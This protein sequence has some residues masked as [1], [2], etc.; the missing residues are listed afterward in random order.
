[1]PK[2]SGEHGLGAIAN[3]TRFAEFRRRVEPA[4]LVA[5]RALYLS[6]SAWTSR[7]LRHVEELLSGESGRVAEF[8]ALAVEIE[9]GL[10]TLAT[11]EEITEEVI[12]LEGVISKKGSVD[13][14]IYVPSLIES[15]LGEGISRLVLQ[16]AFA[17]RREGADWLPT[18]RDCLETVR[19]EKALW[20]QKLKL[21]KSFP[22]ALGLCQLRLE[23]EQLFPAKQKTRGVH[24]K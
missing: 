15:L 2:V 18:I 14:R 17:K 1:M 7:E 24:G 4:S 3:I 19:D 23:R 6:K 9:M 20:W 11:K 10:L 5:S 16:G 13:L 8:D 21:L 22:D 12:L